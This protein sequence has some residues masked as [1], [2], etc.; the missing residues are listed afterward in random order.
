[1]VKSE[2]FLVPAPPL[3]MTLVITL[4]N[5]NEPGKGGHFPF[6]GF[7]PSGQGVGVGH[8]P[9]TGFEPSGQGV[10]VGHFPFTGF[11]PSGQGGGSIGV[12]LPL[13]S[14]PDLLPLPDPVDA[15]KWFFFA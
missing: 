5:V 11:E 8:F 14:L 9:F 2:G 6:T 15:C 4:K 3:F 10:G 12:P 7:E 13:L 1:M